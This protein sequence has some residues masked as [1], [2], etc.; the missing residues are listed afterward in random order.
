MKLNKLKTLQDVVALYKSNDV[1]QKRQDNLLS[2]YQ[3]L[4]NEFTV[5]DVIFPDITIG[6]KT[7][8][9]VPAFAI[10]QD[11]K[12]YITVGTFKQSYTDR[13][14]ATQI[15]KS[16]DQNRNGKFLVVNN[17]A[18]HPFAEGLSEAELILKVL[19]TEKFK[20]SDPKDFRV[21]SG[22]VNEEL[23]FHDTKEAALEAVQ[24]KSYRVISAAL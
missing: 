4:P 22:F 3:T 13:K 18:V 9:N 6:K 17:R 2:K 12:E 24:T 11:G 23:T 20:T 14:E 10:S 15:T 5:Y 21:Y 16:A 7:I 8:Q 1:N 19:Q